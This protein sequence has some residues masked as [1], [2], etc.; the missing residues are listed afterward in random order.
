MFINQKWV[1]HWLTGEGIY[2]P[3]TFVYE[4]ILL[5]LK[6][7]WYI[8]CETYAC[9]GVYCL[10]RVFYTN[11]S[12]IQ[13]DCLFKINEINFSKQMTRPEF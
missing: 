4:L 1:Y 7:S 3:F 12:H 9:Y 13:C 8:V 5:I 10:S 2:K 11:K 6:T